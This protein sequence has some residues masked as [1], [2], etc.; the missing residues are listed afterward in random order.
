M[1]VRFSASDGSDPRSNGRRYSVRYPRRLLPAST[2][3]L[4]A[5]WIVLPPI[6]LTLT[7]RAAQPNPL[8]ILP[9]TLPGW[10]GP[11]AGSIF[12]LFV[13]QAWLLPANGP[14]LL[15][16][17]SVGLVAFVGAVRALR[18]AWP[19]SLPGWSPWIVA[20]LLWAVC[21]AVAGSAFASWRPAVSLLLMAVWGLM[22]YFGL[23]GSGASLEGPSLESRSTG[24][25][26]ALF[27]LAAGVSLV[28]DV[29]FDLAGRL[30][31]LG[32]ATPWTRAVVN[33]WTTKFLGHW[34]LVLV[35]CALAALAATTSTR[36]RSVALVILLGGS[37]VLV[38][39]SKSALVALAVSTAVAL[40]AWRWPRG[41]RRLL[42]GSILC[43][44]LLAP[45][46]AGV[47]WHVYSELPKGWA[48]GRLG[49]L[50]MDIRGGMWEFSRRLI[51]VHPLVGW[52]AGATRSLPGGDLP[53][54]E[55][56]AL[57]EGSARPE[58]LERPTLAGGHPHNAA[59]LTWLDLGLVGA[60]LLAG[61]A[62]AAGRAIAAVEKHRRA[63]AALLGLLATTVTILV[64]NY[65]LW[66]PEVLAMLWMSVALASVAL[67][68]P[69]PDLRR[70]VRHGATAL[71][72]LSIGCGALAVDRLSRWWTVRDLRSHPV[73]LDFAHDRV[74]AGG[75]TRSLRYDSSLAASAELV[76]PG[77]IR[78]WAFD[79]SGGGAPRAV[80]VFVGDELVGVARPELASE[81]LFL[82]QDTPDVRS[83]TAGFL[84]PVTKE[85]DLEAPVTVVALD[86][87]A[88]LVARLPPL[89][90]AG[91]RQEP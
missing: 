10:C 8:G 31:S 4:L 1:V 71:V 36:R 5:G 72:V 39:G 62:L 20:F 53:M 91:P 68:R 70:L 50:E 14:W 73:E 38:N 3:L 77:W 35:W 58:V 40:A 56:L 82:Q 87:G 64:F 49:A 43:G 47:P 81:D 65:P 2:V 29:G 28:R 83:L 44:L 61:L 12:T 67:P 7:R 18:V 21:S 23:R 22:L 51:S 59:L 6:A 79:P 75:E 13:L 90:P 19:G 34:M 60:V 84:I 16:V 45:L 42:T 74:I 24:W 26:L 66:Q 15:A 86:S 33:P 85:L 48:D 46:L 80:L 41:A 63:H 11:I 57:E 52:G 76:Q 78:G 27:C 55:T 25:M 89:T 69:E 88:G 32:L 37:A 54:A 30:A 9:S 17:A